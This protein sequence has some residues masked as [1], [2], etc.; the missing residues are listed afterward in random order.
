M[1]HSPYEPDE[2]VAPVASRRAGNDRHG[3][4]WE[5]RGESSGVG[6]PGHGPVPLLEGRRVTVHG[7]ARHVQQR[8]S[9]MPSDPTQILTFRVDVAGAGG[10]IRQSVSVEM[11]GYDVRGR[12]SDGEQVTVVGVVRGGTVQA[13]SITNATTRSR[14]STP[15]RPLWQKIALGFAVAWVVGIFLLV[16]TG[17]AGFFSVGKGIVDNF[18]SPLAGAPVPEGP[19]PSPTRHTVEIGAG[20]FDVEFSPGSLQIARGDTVVWTNTRGKACTFRLVQGRLPATVKAPG[21]VK[22]RGSLS[23][24]FTEPGTVALECK[25]EFGPPLLVYIA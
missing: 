11:R 19:P 25:G 4:A 15:G 3:E 7:V 2:D 6:G 10:E 14:V 22:P 12:L 9:G 5:Y 8:P 23:M 20:N 13:R 18:G 24:T 1:S 16:G 21:I 17:I